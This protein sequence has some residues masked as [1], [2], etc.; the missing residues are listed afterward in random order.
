MAWDKVCSIIEAGGLGIRRFVNL[1][2]ALLGMW[3]WQFGHEVSHCG[4]K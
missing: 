3:L 2:K 4:S 1:N